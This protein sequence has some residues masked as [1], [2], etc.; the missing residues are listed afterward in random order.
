M[1]FVILALSFYVGQFLWG[2][3]AVVFVFW[4][5]MLSD[6]LQ[7]P[8]EHFPNAGEYEKLIWCLVIIVVNFIGAV[9]YYYLVKRKD[10]DEKE[11][12][13]L[14]NISQKKVI[15]SVLIFFLSLAIFVY[16]GQFF[17]WMI[18]VALLLIIFLIVSMLAVYLI[19]E[20][21]MTQTGKRMKQS[22]KALF[23]PTVTSIKN[24][25]NPIFSY[26]FI[27]VG[28]MIFIP[29]VFISVSP[30]F[31]PL[32]NSVAHVDKPLLS[33][34]I[35]A[36]ANYFYEEELLP[37]Q[38]N[39]QGNYNSTIYSAMRYI[40]KMGYPLSTAKVETWGEEYVR[41][42]IQFVE[43]TVFA[44]LSIS[45]VAM[46]I[47]GL[48]AF[49]KKALMERFL[50]STTFDSVSLLLGSVILL[51]SINYGILADPS[52]LCKAISS[53]TFLLRNLIGVLLLITFSSSG[54]FVYLRT[55]KKEQVFQSDI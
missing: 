29:A 16:L 24:S 36:Q 15:I 10:Q 5:W 27:V 2:I 34:D 51:I 26:S 18:A 46:L 19:K 43:D 17:L 54:L 9:L 45:S 33:D 52:L 3:V 53:G 38:Q 14:N 21:S 23:T 35:I 25:I 48:L 11:S 13:D 1:A 30:G 44:A 37:N 22:L 41:N 4:L 31:D 8:T 6:C 42:R 28:L 55:K 20:S 12:I 32:L 40:N 39:Y 7:R 49:Q 47:G 50:L